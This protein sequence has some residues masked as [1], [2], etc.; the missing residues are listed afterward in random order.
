MTDFLAELRRRNVYRVAVTYTVTGWLFAQVCDMLLPVL[1]LPEAATTAVIVLLALGLPVA[2][3][4]AWIYEAT[5]E[6]FKRTADVAEEES[7]AVDTGRRLNLVTL[8]AVALLIATFFARPWL[9]SSPAT[10]VASQV[11]EQ[12]SVATGSSRR[13]AS[14]AVLPFVDLSPDGDQEYFSDGISEEL[15]NLLAKIPEL[16]VTS[17][18]SAFAFK[19][20]DVG[21]RDVAASLGVAHV[22]EGS[23]RKAGSRLRITAQLI[24]TESDTHLWSE[25]YDRELVDVFAV[26]D[27]I[28]AAIVTELGP[29][30]GISDAPEPRSPR[31]VDSAAY[32][33]YLLGQHLLR[34]RTREKIEAAIVEFQRARALD[35]R[36]APAVAGEA[37]GWYLLKFGPTT[38]GELPLEEVRARVEPLLESAFELDPELPEAFGVRGI[39][40]TSL[41]RLDLALADFE[42][43]LELN[44]SYTDALN[45][46]QALLANLGRREEAMAVLDRLVSLDPLNPVVVR[47]DIAL[48]SSYAPFDDYGDALARLEQLD[49]ARAEVARVLLLDAR[50]E[51]AAVVDAGLKAVEGGNEDFLL[52]ALSAYRFVSSGLEEEGRSIWQGP[53]GIVDVGSADP[54]RVL[55]ARL[56]LHEQSPDD[57]AGMAE[58]AYAY[59]GAGDHDAARRWSDR[60][61]QTAP[62]MLVDS[63][64]LQVVGALLDHLEGDTRRAVARTA[65]ARALVDR[66]VEAGLA[67]RAD[68]EAQAVFLGIAGDRVGALAAL[69]R[70]LASLGTPLAWL[71]LHYR[72]LCWE[73]IPAF[74]AARERYRERLRA[75]QA[76]ALERGCARRYALWTPRS[77]TCRDFGL[78]LAAVP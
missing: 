25:T 46:Y 63:D 54:Q 50:G 62:P 53:G 55:A 65:G 72:I 1:G 21:I 22:L 16:E 73:R 51:F 14:I 44:P 5:P 70:A 42:R 18:S 77:E 61:L 74:V 69:E 15:L 23:V 39:L 20:K 64:R 12:G 31:S 41:G 48:R 30:L 9:V 4:F 47:N 6:G 26:Q 75:E 11:A 78:T 43:A 19:G 60:A 56:A 40:E 28:S 37:L 67:E 3:V 17:R 2:V 32:D 36:Y 27:E 7:V 24:D 52:L 38:Y 35:P 71:D 8:A 66:A 57:P 68:F 45:W 33:A 58:L 29:L 49:R 34:I 76:M 10:G 13:T 59:L